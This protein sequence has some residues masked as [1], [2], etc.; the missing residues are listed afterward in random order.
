SVEAAIQAAADAVAE[1]RVEQLAQRGLE[2][3]DPESRF[4]LLC[5]DVLGAEEF[6]FNEAMLLGRAVN[7][8]DKS[9]DSLMRAGLVEKS[10]DKVK[11]LPA[12]ARRR[13]SAIKEEAKLLALFEM[14]GGGNGKGKAKIRRK[15]HPQDEFFGSAIDMCHALALRYAEAKGGQAGIGAAKG[16]ALQQNWGAESPCARLMAALVKA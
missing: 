11:I 6:R 10:G 13:E 3:V 8:A 14:G 4:V 15:V 9:L 7:P 16:M 12:K 2:G 5:W 1:W